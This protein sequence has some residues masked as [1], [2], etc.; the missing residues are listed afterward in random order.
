M[1]REG[2]CAL[3]DERSFSTP[4]LGLQEER[5]WFSKDAATAGIAFGF[6]RFFLCE[7]ESLLASASMK[8]N[9]NW[10]GAE[11]RQ[12]VSMMIGPLRG[13]LTGGKILPHELLQRGIAIKA[14]ARKA[15]QGIR[16]RV[17][18]TELRNH[19]GPAALFNPAHKEHRR[20][21][22]IAWPPPM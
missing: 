9:V 1:F 3:H 8:L 15:L 2:S 7:G 17:S 16:T 13:R 5:F 21:Y 12:E 20:V 18:S 19:H 4:A 22:G 10:R 14:E 6:G 11:L